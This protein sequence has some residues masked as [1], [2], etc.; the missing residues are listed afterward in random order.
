MTVLDG[1]EVELRPGARKLLTVRQTREYHAHVTLW[2]LDGETWLARSETDGRIGMGGLAHPTQRLERT[3]ATP[4][5]TYRLLHS[6]GTHRRRR[7][8][9]L[10]Y[11]R[12]GPGDYWVGDNSSPHYNRWRSKRE[13]GFR[14]R[15]GEEQ[16]NAS[17]RLADYAV[18]YEYA[19]VIDFNYDEQVRKRGFAIFLHVE[20]ERGTG[21]CVA[22]PRDFMKSLMSELVAEDRPLIA[23]GR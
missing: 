14:T 4:T 11:R 16:P 13:G 22:V 20:G 5:G 21:G 1:I 17:E 9:K 3:M 12:I 10:G 7:A 2:V 18:A 8:W 19:M 6:F 23:I 15:L